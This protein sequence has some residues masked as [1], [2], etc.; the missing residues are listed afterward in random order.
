M[1]HLWSIHSISNF[2]TQCESIKAMCYSPEQRSQQ[3]TRQGKAPVQRGLLSLEDLEIE[4]M[5]RGFWIWFPAK[6]MLRRAG[7][8]S[9]FSSA[10]L[11][12]CLSLSR[13]V[14][15]LPQTLLSTLAQTY[16]KTLWIVLISIWDLSDWTS[17]ILEGA[18]PL[19]NYT[20]TPL[21]TKQ[22]NVMSHVISTSTKISLVLTTLHKPQLN[23][24]CQWKPRDGQ[25]LN[26]IPN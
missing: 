2:H 14:F 23:L 21:K 6:K 9:T 1:I 11:P 7:Q 17:I 20:K 18:P 13:L 4:I 26:Y 12:A 16:R 10:H 8:R 19:W 22:L 5:Q 3:E 24:L 25:S 15:L